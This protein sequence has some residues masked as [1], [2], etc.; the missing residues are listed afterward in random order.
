MASMWMILVFA[1]ATL[2]GFSMCG[3]MGVS[4]ILGLAILGIPL[5]TLARIMI[6]ELRGVPLLAVPFFI[7]A[8]QLMNEM[9]ITDRIFNFANHLVGRLPGGLAQVNVASSVFF[10]GIS[11]SAL[12]DIGGLGAML[13]RAM[14]RHGYRSAFAAA[15]SVVSSVI[16]PLI[17][18][19]IMFVIFAVNM[20]VSIGRLFLAGVF[21]GLV[22]AAVLMAT[23]FVLA[24]TGRE[25]CPRSERA[26]LRQILRDMATGLPAIVSPGIIV[27]GLVL[28][29]V[30]PTEASVV[31]VLYSILIG[32]LYGE[33][34]VD[35]LFRAFRDTCISTSVI[36]VLTALGAVMAYV[37]T[38]ERSADTIA[39]W[40]LAISDSP[41]FALLAINLILIVMGMFIE[42]VPAMLISIPLLGPVALA[43]GV[44]PV[45]FGVILVFNL[46]IGIVTPP[47]GIGIFTISAV[48]GV[49]PEAVIR[50]TLPFYV[51]LFIS[52]ILLT[53]VPSISL[54]LPRALM[55]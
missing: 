34:K 47:V 6:E 36:M 37:V 24:R 53:L 55:G 14:E 35:R 7:L 4:A 8:A 54:W 17:P 51:S 5:A 41:L 50:A 22:I 12:A 10:A 52:L 30:T 42:T 20:N 44:D 48:T 29:L 26:P 40:I 18:P 43:A 23:I 33:C 1:A 11:G 3:A 25:H 28:G 2:L 31:A 15:L 46:L 49:R 32:V 19:S 39:R 27:G 45:H 38:A 16:A 21:P 13:V 9:R